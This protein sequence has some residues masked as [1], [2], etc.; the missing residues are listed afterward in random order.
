M[1][2]PLPAADSRRRKTFPGPPETAQP[3]ALQGMGLNSGKGMVPSPTPSMDG[4]LTFTRELPLWLAE[5]Q[6]AAAGGLRG[7]RGWE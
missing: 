3:S 4:T 6:G 7:A 5:D 2:Y 1:R